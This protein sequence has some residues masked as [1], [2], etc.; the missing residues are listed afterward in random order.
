[1]AYATPTTPSGFAAL[2]AQ[3]VW[4]EDCNNQMNAMNNILEI[5][6]AL[7]LGWAALSPIRLYVASNEAPGLAD[8]ESA[9]VESGRTLP[10]SGNVVGI[11]ETLTLAPKDGG[12]YIW[13]ESNMRPTLA[14]WWNGSRETFLTTPGMYTNVNTGATWAVGIA[15]PLILQRAAW[16]ESMYAHDITN[17]GQTYLW[18]N[19]V[20]LLTRGALAGDASVSEAKPTPFWFFSPAKMS[21]GTLEIQFRVQ[22]GVVSGFSMV[23]S[24][25]TRKYESGYMNFASGFGFLGETSALVTKA[26]YLD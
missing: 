11:W 19:T 10:I 2:I 4:P 24:G 20:D 3:I 13:V 1:M 15:Q 7:K 5:L 22:S 17:N 6:S 9:W 26:I 14:R 21:S 25:K 16:I 8:W 23:N 18:R 12:Q